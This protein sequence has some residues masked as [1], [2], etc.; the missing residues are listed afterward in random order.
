M[1]NTHR[2]G[3]NRLPPPPQVQGRFS[4]LPALAILL[5]MYCG[6]HCEPLFRKDMA[7]LQATVDSFVHGSSYCDDQAFLPL[8]TCDV[9][10]LQERKTLEKVSSQQIKSASFGKVRP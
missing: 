10:P 1:C 4:V 2:Y 9:L 3:G 7:C 8:K 5:F 6:V